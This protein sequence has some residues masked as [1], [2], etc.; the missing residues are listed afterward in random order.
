MTKARD[1]CS[2][3][4]LR[5]GADISIA[6]GPD[7]IP[8]TYRDLAGHI[9]AE[10]RGAGYWVWK[11]II[12][13]LQLRRMQ[14]GQHLVYTDS[15]L[16]IVGNLRYITDRNEDLFLFSN[17]FIHQHWCKG[18]VLDLFNIRHRVD[19]QCQASA[20]FV[21]RSERT[22]AFVRDWL[23]ACLYKPS[24]DDSDSISENHPEFQEHRHDQALLTCL[25]LRHNIPLHWYPAKYLKDHNPK[26]QEG[27]PVLF[28]HH[29][30]RNHEL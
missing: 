10:E 2:K 1:I 14:D 5:H 8:D 22:L 6:M 20:I 21:K 4:A 17:G 30:R 7:D 27:Y 9:L 18:D 25:S 29:R 23:T 24:I 15:G 12:I 28:F 19:V 13:Y 11:P 3:S 26:P 16:E